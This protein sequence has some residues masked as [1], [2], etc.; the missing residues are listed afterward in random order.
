VNLSS[1]REYREAQ[2]GW[3]GK[4]PA[5]WDTV[6]MKYLFLQ[7]S[8]KGHPEE[9]LL[10]ATQTKGV[11]P[12]E[13]YENRTVVA[14]KDLHLLKLVEVGDFVISLRSFQGGI[15]YARF[16]GI[17]SPAYTV[18]HPGERIN[19]VFFTYLFKS[20]PYIDNLSLYVT[21][22]RQG[23]NIDYERL[24][25][26]LLPVPPIEEQA[27]ISKYLLY[28]DRGLAE[29]MRGLRRLA[30]GSRSAQERR[31]SLL[32]EYRTR[33]I[34]DVVTGKL[35]VRGLAPLSGDDLPEAEPVDLGEAIDD[36][37]MQPND[38]PELVEE[39]ADD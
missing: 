6:K 2:E 29:M 15:E 24:S 35:D 3:L 27:V 16:R 38:E 28:V 14:M 34:A 1:Y 9:P 11:V 10:A 30:G 20:R 17:I 23:Q 5:H 21:G 7:N 13:H 12:K 39:S 8:E 4:V 26:S 25:R 19:T 18:L 22:I 32:F 33:L 36:N 31:S 37:M